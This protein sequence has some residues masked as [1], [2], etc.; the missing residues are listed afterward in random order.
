MCRLSA[1]SLLKLIIKL[2]VLQFFLVKSAVVTV[3]MGLISISL[4][5][6]GGGE[7]NRGQIE[8]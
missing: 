7:I 6:R 3:H 5:K 8:L 2:D 4:T 1:L